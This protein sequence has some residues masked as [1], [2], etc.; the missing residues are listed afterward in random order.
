[1][2]KQIPSKV[3]TQSPGKMRIEIGSKMYTQVPSNIR[4]VVK[5]MNTQISSQISTQSSAKTNTKILGKMSSHVVSKMNA[6]PSKIRTQV[7]SKM[8]TQTPSKM[9]KKSTLNAGGPSIDT[10]NEKSEYISLKSPKSIEIIFKQE[11]VDV[12]NPTL[13]EHRFL[14]HYKPLLKSLKKQTRLSTTEIESL[15]LLFHKFSSGTELMTKGEFVDIMSKTL[16]MSDDFM[17]EKIIMEILKSSK[18]KRY[19]TIDIWVKVLS[20]YL[21]GTMEEKMEYCFGI[22]DITKKGFIKKEILY[23]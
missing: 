4:R 7:F 9:S 12:F 19:I 6:I 21:R 5:R 20:L 22:Y 10:I 17:S 11:P 16:N 13:E 1:M 14:K 18:L 2:S 8:N 3:R 15:M 23:M